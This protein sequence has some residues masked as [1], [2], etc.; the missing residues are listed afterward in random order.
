MRLRTKMTLMQIISTVVAIGTLSWIF[1]YQITEYAEVEMQTFRSDTL[2]EKKLQLKDFVQMATG[3]VESYYNRSQDIEGLKKA[4]LDDLKRLVDAV[5][6]QVSAYY[7]RNKNRIS[8]KEL[9][10]GLNELV[11]P[12]RY[13]DGNYIWVH[14]LDNIML[15]HPSDKLAGKDASQLTDKK[16]SR[17]VSDMTEVA[18]A[19]G[20]GMTS[21]WWAKPG[22]EEPKLKISYVR[23]LKEAG[24]IVGTGAWIEDITSAMKAEALQQLAKMRQSDGN[25]FWVNNL[26]PRVIMNPANPALD[27]K[28][29]GDMQDTKGKYFFRAMVDTVQSSGQGYV[30]YY[31]TKPGQKG[32]VPKLSFVKL[33]KPWEWVIGMG[34]YIDDIDKAVLAKKKA[35]DATV[36]SIIFII[37]G[38]S[39][40]FVTAGVV[41]GLL[42]SRS[43]I[44]AIGG[45]PNDI[46]EVADAIS[47]GDLTIAENDE[48]HREA[49]GI[50]Q[51]MKEMADNL[52]NVVG[53]VQSATDNLAASSEEL[54]TS[55]EVLSQSTT[56]QSASIEEVSSSL[57][58]IV[59]SI[60]DNV[61]NAESTRQTAETS[62]QEI[63]SGEATV[64]QAIN[65]MR[66]IAEKI[67]FIE[68]IA[69]QTNLLALNAAIEAARAG[70]NGKGFAVVAAEV[71]KLAERSAATAQEINELSA[72]SVDIAEKTGELFARIKPEIASTTE[73]IQKVARLCAEQQEG[74]VRIEKAVA[75]FNATI[76]QN[77]GA[78]EEMAATSEELAS[79]AA[80]LQG[81]LRYFTVKK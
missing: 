23:L 62:N 49:T 19:H 12:A 6:G 56:E 61:K 29:V 25:Y 73:R 70:E 72:T 51:S 41:V 44:R 16:G 81:T 39:L 15:A 33:F 52:N 4:K 20:S 37:L 28:L 21:Y 53:D 11:V 40:L 59:E 69:R 76:Q 64:R 45:E 27:G 26:E 36:Q 1:V 10:K 58:L 42:G 22:E 68:E 78:S 32:D 55:S 79:Q 47:K 35:L 54:S 2:A 50:L 31:W 67:V 17:I 66:K 77:A 43:V 34:V 30:P 75:Q 5:Y 13:D 46:A 48:S 9:L 7:K 60:H 74:A 57:S 65:A 14:D 18:K 71:R 38:I 8:E 63:H 24:W 3:T 80:S